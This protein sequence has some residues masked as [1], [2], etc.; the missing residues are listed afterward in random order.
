[1]TPSAT[2]NPAPPAPQPLPRGRHGIAPEDVRASQH[3]RLT[4]AILEL[5][6]RQGYAATTVAQIAAEAR[7]SPNRFYDFFENKAACFV[8][9][10]DQGGTELLGLELSDWRSALRDGMRRY[11]AWWRD[12]PELSHAYFLELPT[13]GEV[14]HAQRAGMYGRFHGLFGAL[15]ARARVEEPWLPAF[16]PHAARLL[17]AG[18]TN[19]VGEEVRQGRVGRLPD[20]ED[21]LTRLVAALIADPAFMP[22]PAAAEAR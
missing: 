8:A 17:V 6:A 12:R 13:A 20:L 22:D 5:V 7:V 14:A 2:S 16:S 3:A 1:M 18:I 9:V 11:L 21:D 4:V 15:A 10:C 19:V